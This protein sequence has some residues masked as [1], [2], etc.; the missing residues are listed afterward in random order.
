[1]EHCQRRCNCTT[2]LG[3][4]F[5]YLTDASAMWLPCMLR[6]ITGFQ[7]KTSHF[8]MCVCVHGWWWCLATHAE[9]LLQTEPDQIDD[10]SIPCV[11]SPSSR[12]ILL[13]SLPASLGS[14]PGTPS[15]TG[16]PQPG[17]LPSSSAPSWS[18]LGFP[19]SWLCH[20]VDLI[21]GPA[22]HPASWKGNWQ[23]SW[24]LYKQENVMSFDEESF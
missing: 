19:G 5:P 17:Q 14:L 15:Q 24:E 16:G 6:S 4:N 7:C 23:L 18:L 11:F 21:P 9:R 1:M 2:C 12:S 13:A 22:V 3:Q 20:P 10:N 8:S